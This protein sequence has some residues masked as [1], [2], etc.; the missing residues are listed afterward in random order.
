MIKS[1]LNNYFQDLVWFS[2]IWHLM[3]CGALGTE[4]GY[5]LDTLLCWA[6]LAVD[7]LLMLDTTTQPQ[8]LSWWWPTFMGHF[9]CLLLVLSSFVVFLS[10]VTLLLD[11]GWKDN[12]VWFSISHVQLHISLEPLLMSLLCWRKVIQNKSGIE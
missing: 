12:L 10:V 2:V 4:S 5:T 8:H 3:W 7:T 9:M 1:V 6:V 11:G